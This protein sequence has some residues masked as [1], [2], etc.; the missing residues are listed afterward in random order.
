MHYAIAKRAYDGHRAR[1]VTAIKQGGFRV[2]T[3]R[4]EDDQLPKLAHLRVHMR[5]WPTEAKAAAALAQIADV[6]GY[7]DF[8]VVA[9]PGA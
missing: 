1:Y 4:I 5:L 9:M 3:S 2:D 7:D 6:G 8:T